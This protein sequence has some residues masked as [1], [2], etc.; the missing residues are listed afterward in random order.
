M[1]PYLTPLI[2]INSNWIEDLNVRPEAVN[3]EK[4]I[5][6]K[7]LEIGLGNDFLD[8]TQK[9]QATKAKINK[10][11]YIKPEGFATA[12]ATIIKMKR[13]PT[14]QEKIFASH[15]ADKGL[16]YKIFKNSDKSIANRLITQIKN[17]QR[18]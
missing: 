2:K 13:Q 14:E 3:L 1:D 6:K 7:L 17:G 15:K 10:W 9:A 18:T 12:K 8:M 11:D 4:N 16:I 5:V